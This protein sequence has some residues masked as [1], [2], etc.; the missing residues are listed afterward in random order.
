MPFHSVSNHYQK[1]LS[2]NKVFLILFMFETSRLFMLKGYA[3][4]KLHYEHGRNFPTLPP[5]LSMEVGWTA[6]RKALLSPDYWLTR[7]ELLLLGACLGCRIR[8]VTF[9]GDAKQVHDPD[10]NAYISS[11]E[12]EVTV[13]MCLSGGN[14]TR[15]HFS[16]MLP[17]VEVEALRQKLYDGYKF[18]DGVSESGEDKADADE[19]SDGQADSSL[20]LSSCSSSMQESCNDL[21]IDG[22][23]SGSTEHDMEDSN[24][25]ADI[26]GVDDSSSLFPPAAFEDHDTE[27]EQAKS[28]PKAERDIF[29]DEFSDVSSN[30]DLF[31]V[32]V[33]PS[34]SFITYEDKDFQYVLDLVDKLRDYPLM[35]PSC[36]D[37]TGSHMEV[38]S[39]V[40]FPC[41]HCAFKGCIANTTQFSG[42]E[43]WAMERWLFLHL[44]H[45]H[46]NNE[47]RDIVDNCCSHT[48]DEKEMTLLAYYLAAV[49]EKERQHMPLI[50]PCVDRR[51][52]AMVHKLS[53][54]DNIHGVI[55][56]ACAQ[57]HTHVSSWDR[58][59]YNKTEEEK[60]NSYGDHGCQSIKWYK[61]RE[62]I[63]KLLAPFICHDPN[64][65][66]EKQAE[67]AAKK[68][69]A[70]LNVYNQTFLLSEFVHRFANKTNDTHLPWY[71][72]TEIADGDTE[73][74][75]T[76]IIS[77]K[78]FDVDLTSRRDRII[79][80]PEDVK[81]C[82]RAH[83]ADEIC[84]DC[85]IP[86]CTDC[87][88][89][90]QG[91]PCVPPM[92]LC[93][94]NLWGYTT[95]II[96]RYKVRWLEAAI[97]SPCWT[98]MMVFYVEGDGGHLFN[99]ELSNQRY[100]TK[101]SPYTRN[102]E[103]VRYS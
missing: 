17:S 13:A 83:K 95:D 20:D 88:V 24:D 92:G 103:M 90:L 36:D 94:D 87:M 6:L 11:L 8:V 44:K 38:D 80:C 99:E 75:R 67:E 31:H 71:G 65:S 2:I 5:S 23:S 51:S 70:A 10:E 63:F 27:A 25:R 93:N 97:V 28:L 86:L 54:S 96:W 15:G 77:G 12:L 55:C 66:P 56:F 73:W 60:A 39:G 26:S 35:P 49:R 57:I 16:R 74:Q 68:K 34:R 45:V 84:G 33:N 46:G 48:T 40:R 102:R 32:A 62:S 29:I 37:G 1:D 100:R 91:T 72:A 50:G 41:C 78:V 98:S 9:Y 58:M 7:E 53:R 69:Q 47:L 76:L 79:C 22:K 52:L 18:L 101:V 64:L 89:C 30:S 14:T 4:L 3:T 59:W 21:D 43:H 42:Q 85:D 82:G 19:M 81:S 61:V